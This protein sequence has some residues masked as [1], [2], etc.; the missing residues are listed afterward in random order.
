MTRLSRLVEINNTNFHTSFQY[1]N[2]VLST[3]A[4]TVRLLRNTSETEAGIY[5]DDL[6]NTEQVFSNSFIQAIGVT[7]PYNGKMLEVIAEATLDY[8][9]YPKEAKQPLSTFLIY[10]TNNELKV[11]NYLLNTSIN[12]YR[13]S[14]YLRSLSGSAVCLAQVY[15]INANDTVSDSSIS[16]VKLND[17]DIISNIDMSSFIKETAQVAADR[18][19]PKSRFQPKLIL[20]SSSDTIEEDAEV[21]FRVTCELNNKVCT[22]ANF[23]VHIEPVDGYVAH[24]RITLQDGEAT[25]TAQALNL[26]DGETMRIKVGLPHYTG[27]AEKVV[28]VVA[29]PKKEPEAKTTEELI[30]EMKAAVLSTEEIKKDIKDYSENLI[31][32]GISK[33]LNE[34]SALNS[35]VDRSLQSMTASLDELKKAQSDFIIKASQDNKAS[36]DSIKAEL[37]K[38]SKDMLT[39][40]ADVRDSLLEALRRLKAGEDL[41][42]LDV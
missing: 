23:I 9:E 28:N 16:L 26:K 37:K 39:E 20:S 18:N 8:D 1:I 41:S 36:M 3:N 4:L 25:F 21:T 10:L 19:T 33:T 35:K 12:H 14:D 2:Y 27:L 6:Y 32:S 17:I 38:D 22:E 24:K 30:L 7:V 13:S 31:N 34:F 42:D 11:D 29:K 40:L 15:F 5:E